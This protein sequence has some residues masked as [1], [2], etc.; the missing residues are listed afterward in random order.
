MKKSIA[1]IWKGKQQG[2]IQINRGKI[3]KIVT[4]NGKIEK[5]NFSFNRDTENKLKIIFDYDVE[6]GSHGPIVNVF[7]ERNPFSFLSSI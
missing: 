7:T 1:I 2:T 3:E 6:N 4:E 5:N